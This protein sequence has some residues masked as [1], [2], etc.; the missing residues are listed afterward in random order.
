[1]KKPNISIGA[2]SKTIPL[3]KYSGEW[4][5][6]AEGKVVAHRESLKKLMENVKAEKA[7]EEAF[8]FVGTL[9]KERNHMFNEK[10]ILLPKERRPGLSAN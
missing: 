3:D 9:R 1:M 5:A 4:V 7:Q 6:F 2:S 8:G 10:G